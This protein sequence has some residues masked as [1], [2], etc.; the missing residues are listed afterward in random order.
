MSQ[1][2]QKLKRKN[3]EELKR[4][5]E[6][7]LIADERRMEHISESIDKIKDN[8]LAHIQASMA[9]LEARYQGLAADIQWLKWGLMAILAG[10]I[11]VYFK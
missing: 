8:H 2:R 6:E 11:G 3:M 5:F 4:R 7:H 1:S 9:E 10:I